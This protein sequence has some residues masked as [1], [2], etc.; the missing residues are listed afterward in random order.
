MG[1]NLACLST[2]LGIFCLGTRDAVRGMRNRGRTLCNQ[3]HTLE[4]GKSLMRGITWLRASILSTKIMQVVSRM[5]KFLRI[6]RSYRTN[7]QRAFRPS[8][9]K[10]RDMGETIPIDVKADINYFPATAELIE[11]RYWKP[12]LLGDADE[13]TR[14]TTIQNV[15]GMESDFVLDKNGFQFVNL[16]SKPRDASTDE[17]IRGEYYAEIAEVLK[18]LY[19]RSQQGVSFFSLVTE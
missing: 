12:R 6:A 16:P 5:H 2:F 15:R 14:K 19:A 8:L 4:E 3:G 9:R 13:H 1:S 10:L 7:S 18:E 11:T 17:K